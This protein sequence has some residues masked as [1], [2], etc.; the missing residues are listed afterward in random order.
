MIRIDRALGAHDCLVSEPDNG[1][2]HGHRSVRF[3]PNLHPHECVQGRGFHDKSTTAQRYAVIASLMSGAWLAAFLHCC[4]HSTP[5]IL[6]NSLLATGS[7]RPVLGILL[8]M[9]AALVGWFYSPTAAVVIFRI[10][11][12]YDAW[13][14][15][16]F[17]AT[18][19]RLGSFAADGP[20]C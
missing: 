11:L 20:I 1:R 3:I 8:A 16:A 12:G 10:I 14:A 18:K 17:I 15:G 4:R 5:A 13:Q 2:H 7:L 19:G 6:P 9:A